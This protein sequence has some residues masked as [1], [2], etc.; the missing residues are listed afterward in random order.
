VDIHKGNSSMMMV[1][2][3]LMMVMLVVM[4]TNHDVG[5]DVIDDANNHVDDDVG[6]GVRRCHP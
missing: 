5:Y 3:M 4:L 6:N 1:A 2:M